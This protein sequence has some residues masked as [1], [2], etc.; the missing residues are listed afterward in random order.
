MSACAAAE[1]VGAWLCRAG[2]LLRAAA[3]DNPRLEARWLLA[4]AMGSSTEALLRDPHAPVPP[5]AAERFA[6]MLARRAGREP[7]AYVLGHA[8]FWGLDLLVSPA[9]LIPRPDSETLVEAALA[10]RPAPERVLDL[11]TGTGCLLLAVLQ[12][13]PGAFGVGVDLSPAA[14]ALAARNAQRLGLSGRAAFLVADWSAPLAGR[15]DLILCNPPYVAAAE[16][17]RLMPEV[18]LHEPALALVGGEDGLAAYRRIAPLLPPLLAPGGVAVV[19]IGAGQGPAV[20][21]LM[22]RA[23]LVLRELRPDLGGIPRAM[24]LQA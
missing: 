19:E 12:E 13:V 17:P 3:I 15:F 14:A 18:R 10:A 16:L 22:R 21:E 7:L 24:V 1:T 4:E 5:A 11:G 23:G 6:R 20:A 8:G 9:T 2:Q